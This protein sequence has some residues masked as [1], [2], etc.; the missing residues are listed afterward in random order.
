VNVLLTTLPIGT[1]FLASCFVFDLHLEKMKNAYTF[2]RL[3]NYPAT[4]TGQ[5]FGVG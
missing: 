2:S 3:K 1:D 5:L 4:W